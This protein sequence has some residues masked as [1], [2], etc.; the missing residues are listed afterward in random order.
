VLGRHEE[1]IRFSVGME[2]FEG[3]SLNLAE[4]LP[5]HVAG[6]VSRAIP[7]DGLG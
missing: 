2:I 1:N 5:P 7:L 4:L 3:F 6:E